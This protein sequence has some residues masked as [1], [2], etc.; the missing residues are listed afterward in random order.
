MTIG[1]LLIDDRDGR[2]PLAIL[3][4]LAV[5]AAH[6]H[7]SFDQ[8]YE[9]GVSRDSCILVS[10]VLR[11]FLFRIGFTDAEVRSV[12]FLVERRTGDAPTHQLLVGEPD[13]RDKGGRWNG[14]MVV[15]AGGWLIDG[16]LY[17]A[18]REHWDFLPGMVATPVRDRQM[19]VDGRRVITGF[20]ARQDDTTVQG[21]WL[22][23]PENKRWRTAPD[24]MRGGRRERHRRGVADLL[25]QYCQRG[26]VND[27]EVHV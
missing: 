10:T 3:K 1:D 22:D 11:D 25:V 4:A 27:E 17:Q 2:P 12:S 23:I 19:I 26:K 15:I 6:L 8:F 21:V 24:I 16:T 13:G 7:P 5:I 14:H 9:D 18:R 20:V